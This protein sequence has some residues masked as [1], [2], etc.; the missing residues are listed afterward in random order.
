MLLNEIIKAHYQNTNWKRQ[1]LALAIIRGRG[2]SQYMTTPSDRTGVAKA[3][4][5]SPSTYHRLFQIP[6]RTIDVS[7]VDTIPCVFVDVDYTLKT[8][9]WGE[10]Y[11][12][13]LDADLMP[14]LIV[15]TPH[16]LHL[17]WYLEK[18][19][20]MR[21]QKDES[22][23]WGPRPEAEKALT[24]WRDIS[25]SL[26]RRLIAMGIPADTAGA[27]SPARLLRI[28]TPDT[29][30]HW[31]PDT[32]WTLQGLSDRLES[33]RLAKSYVISP[34]KR[35]N[36][37]EGVNEGERNDICWRLAL[38]LAHEFK[39][40]PEAGW[41]AL[42]EWCSRCTPAYPV[43]EARSV[44]QWAVRK[45]ARG[46]GVVYRARTGERT[47]EEQGQYAARVYRSKAD[48]AIARAEATLRADGIDPWAVHGGLKMIARLSG[49]SYRTVL[50]RKDNIL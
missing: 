11:V 43:A 45:I 25:F 2:L 14:T 35:V 36:L 37:S 18:P 27:G 42:L 44:W 5:W 13:L 23:I 17:Y 1:L 6:L 39:H 21:W 47:R 10:V 31:D 38:V 15:R 16:G 3:H 20:V 8:P 29:I 34:G 22:G 49:V 4:Y 50:R 41:K 24:W 30:C 40:G 28:P 26:H 48:E 9:H 46:E 32:L 7:R 19:L 12:S 33:Y